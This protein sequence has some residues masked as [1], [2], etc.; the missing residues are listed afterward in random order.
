MI[1]ITEKQNLREEKAISYGDMINAFF[2]MLK[3]DIVVFNYIQLQLNDGDTLNINNEFKLSP[4]S[5]LHGSPLSLV[6]IDKKTVLDIL[7]RTYSFIKKVIVSNDR[8][9]IYRSTGI[10]SLRFAKNGIAKKY[11]MV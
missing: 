10:Y 8:V 6:S 5:Q 2:Q 9:T 11:F 4:F 1:I 3:D 7:N